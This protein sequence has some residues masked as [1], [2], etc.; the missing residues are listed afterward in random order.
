MELIRNGLETTFNKTAVD[1]LCEHRE[2]ERWYYI[3]T[4]TNTEDPDKLVLVDNTNNTIITYDHKELLDRI[5]QDIIGDIKFQHKYGMVVHENPKIQPRATLIFS[6]MIAC[7]ETEFNN[8]T[9][10][11]RNK[12]ILATNENIDYLNNL[13]A[14][15]V[16]IGDRTESPKHDDDDVAFF[17]HMKSRCHALYNHIYQMGVIDII[18]K[19]SVIRKYYTPD[20]NCTF[21]K[22]T[23][24]R[25]REYEA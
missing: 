7:S 15:Y 4:D 21:A 3:T 1:I 16:T 23:V 17:P 24:L 25:I 2:L 12:D 20:Q 14:N 6:M 5:L 13:I 8:I 11:C 10:L 9:E 19:P 22:E 18:I